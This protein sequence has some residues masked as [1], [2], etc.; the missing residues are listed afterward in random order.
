[1]SAAMRR[2]LM[3]ILHDEE[4]ENQIFDS[5][6]FSNK[7]Q[8]AKEIS[9]SSFIHCNLDSANISRS[10]FE[11]VVFDECNISNVN[12]DMARLTDVEFSNCKIVGLSLYRCDQTVFDLIFRDC[13][14]I[15]CN[16]SDAK[17]KRAKFINCEIE[18]SYFQNTFLFESNFSGTNFRNTLFDK[19]D[20]RNSTFERATGYSIDPR[21]NNIAKCVF[22]IPE[23]L[24]LL[25]GFDITIK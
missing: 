24:G 5:V 4:I 15:V 9:D 18:G 19:S 6:D 14:I 25:N 8:L 21:E 12:N 23:V 2:S 16:F 17:M 1:M 20:L 11:K 22:P 13:R 7:E 10:R 3:D